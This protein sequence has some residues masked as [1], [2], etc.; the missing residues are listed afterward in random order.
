MK[1]KAV[2]LRSNPISPDPAVE[3]VASALLEKKCDVII[4]G[5]DR[6]SK[7]DSVEEEIELPS[8]TAKVV[9]FGIPAVF[10]GGMKN[11]SALL[12]FQLR[13]R[14]WIKQHAEQI[15]VIYAFDFDT[16]FAVRKLAKKYKKKFVYHILDFYAASRF[17]SESFMYKFI[18]N[19]EI[20][21]INSADAVAIC[22][23]GRKKQIEGSNPKHL[24]I[25]HN[26]PGYSETVFDNREKTSEKKMRIGY[27]GCFEKVR[28]LH[29]L[30]EY[31][32][33]DERL[34]LHIGGF[35]IIE[36]YVKAC[37]ERCG[38]IIF[39]GKMPYKEALKLE[40]SCDVMTAMYAPGIEN[41]RFIAPNK[42]YEAM[43]LGKPIILC[44]NTGWDELVLKE[45]IGVLIEPS[46]DGIKAGVEEL[47]ARSEEWETMGR[48]S[49]ELYNNSYS[50]DI[51]K[52][53][54]WNMYDA[55][56]PEEK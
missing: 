41:H 52:K 5:W 47:F 40:S 9:R 56:Y 24:E 39:Y 4:V 34:E 20:S 19:R 18:R 37:S 17:H 36:D 45:K 49:K 42:L 46:K 26:T 2:L 1:R 35:G 11:L 43:M 48:R 54:I 6:A 29:E 13:L 7:Y 22:S 51:M 55:L 16:G 25:I 12:R 30:L 10:S 23:E 53:R 21:V 14:K 15:D 50:W 44:K 32:M 3:K 8:G 33:E 38:R 27:V 28:L 31:V